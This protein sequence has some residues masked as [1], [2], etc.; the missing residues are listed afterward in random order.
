MTVSAGNSFLAIRDDLYAKQFE[1][2]DVDVDVD[3]DLPLNRIVNGSPFLC[4]IAFGRTRLCVSAQ[5]LKE[6]G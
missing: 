3:V 2:V 5:W 6:R 1:D 4:V